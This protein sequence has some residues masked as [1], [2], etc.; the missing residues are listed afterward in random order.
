MTTIVRGFLL[1]LGTSLL[2]RSE[3]GARGAEFQSTRSKAGPGPNTGDFEFYVWIN[4]RPKS[5]TSWK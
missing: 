5:S 4:L 1:G 3:R 2:K